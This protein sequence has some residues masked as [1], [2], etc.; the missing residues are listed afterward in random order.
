[1]RKSARRGLCPGGKV[2]KKEVEKMGKKQEWGM[3]RVREGG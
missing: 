1:M 2:R 3:G